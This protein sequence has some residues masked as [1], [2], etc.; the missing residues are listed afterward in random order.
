M[1][2][3]IAA[4][5]TLLRIRRLDLDAA[6]QALAS[7][8]AAEHEAVGQERA[9][10]A[11]IQREF[12]AAAAIDAPDAAVEAFAAWLPRGRAAVARAAEAHRHAAAAT[13]QARASLA[14]ARAAVESTE[15]LL[16]ARAQ[17]ARVEAEQKLQATLDE[18][19]RVRRRP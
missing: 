12:D 7:C 9:A 5:R 2:T 10:E 8:V 15:Q 17:A 14:L 1:P 16:E 11:A 3:S 19:G 4:L 6:Q 13:T 18:A